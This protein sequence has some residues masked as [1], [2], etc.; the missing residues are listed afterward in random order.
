MVRFLSLILLPMCTMAFTCMVPTKTTNKVQPL[1]MEVSRRDAFGTAFLGIL[2]APSASYAI[3]QIAD[4]EVIQSHL[5]TG[6]KLDLNNAF[7][8]SYT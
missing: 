2:S 3:H 7:I 5:P 4:N 8:V 1:F 6:G